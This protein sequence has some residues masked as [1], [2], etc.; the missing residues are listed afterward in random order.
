MGRKTLA[1]RQLRQHDLLV[2]LELSRVVRALDVG[3]QEAGELDRL[4][5]GFEEGVTVRLRVGGGRRDL[6]RRA[7]E[8]RIGHLTGDGALPDQ[9]VEA[10]LVFGE[11]MT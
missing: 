7:L 3:A 11:K 8:A 9:V 1:L 5:G 10:V 4:A 6:R 2:G